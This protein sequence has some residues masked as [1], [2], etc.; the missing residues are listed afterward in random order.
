MS[1]RR[2]GSIRLVRDGVYRVELTHG[3]DPWS[4][5]RAYSS[6]N[7]QGTERDAEI[8]LAR[9][10]VGIGE[11]PEAKNV[12]VGEFIERIYLP[13]TEGTVRRE[14]LHGYKIKLDNHVLP[15][16]RHT[17]L[18][19][20]DVFDLKAWKA[21]LLEQM[22]ERSALNVYRAFFT[23]LER[24]VDW[25]FS[26][27]NPLRG[28]DAP[29]P[30]ER[31]VA[32][33]SASEFMSYVDAFTGHELAPAVVLAVSTG[34]RPCEV[35]AACWE[36]IDFHEGEVRC[37]RGLHES[38]SET[39]FE[40]TKTARSNRSVPLSDW[41]VELLRPLRGIGPLVPSDGGHM[42]PTELQRKY[43][44]HLKACGLRY[45]PMRDL[46]HTYGTLMIEAG[47]PLPIVSRMMGHSTTAITDRFY[48]RPH[49]SAQRD[50][51]NAL[52]ALL[53]ATRGD[54]S[55]ERQRATT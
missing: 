27:A 9:M 53:G 13:N 38:K 16:Y 34:F 22:C 50:A 28:V 31:D 41:A 39:W 8:I 19:A 2:V 48:V 23:A 10:V 33:L 5:K 1:R 11:R 37:H 46:R 52:D 6:E 25:G 42:K 55:T 36:D 54:N 40:P 17:R 47:V 43:R 21:G 32:T 12:T 44:R 3:V 14:T 4:G 15:R 29:I 35:A 18:N 26:T 49:K 30:P 24:A 51:V 20:L 45:V 7:V